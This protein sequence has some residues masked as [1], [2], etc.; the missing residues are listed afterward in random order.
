MARTALHAASLTG[1]TRKRRPSSSCIA[2]ELFGQKT[3]FLERALIAGL[4]FETCR[5]PDNGAQWGENVHTRS[6]SSFRVRRR[7]SRCF[8]G[9]SRIIEADIGTSPASL[10]TTFYRSGGNRAAA[11]GSEASVF[12]C[13]EQG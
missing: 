13:W 5:G 4:S 3:F 12:L 9:N 1:R 8:S 7:S 6:S 2:T 10:S 11:H